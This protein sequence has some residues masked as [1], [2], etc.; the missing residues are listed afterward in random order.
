VAADPGTPSVNL[1]SSSVEESAAKLR[2]AATG[3]AIGASLGGF[4]TAL[5]VLLFPPS[6]ALVPIILAVGTGTVGAIGIVVGQSSKRQNSK[7]D[8]K[9]SAIGLHEIARLGLAIFYGVSHQGFGKAREVNKRTLS[10][11]VEF[12]AKHEEPL[13]LKDWAQANLQEI[14]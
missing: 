4:A 7:V 10:T 13:V 5:G 12:V 14:I 9:P 11:L 6:A 1:H 2:G 3:G 8:G